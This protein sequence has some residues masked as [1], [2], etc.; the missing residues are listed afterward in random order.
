MKDLPLWTLVVNIDGGPRFNTQAS[1][2]TPKQAVR[3]WLNGDLKYSTG[4]EWQK[5]FSLNSAIETFR[6]TGLQNMH[7]CLVHGNGALIEVTVVRTEKRS[8]PN[9]ALK[10]GRAKKRRAA[11]R[12]S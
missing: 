5:R 3:L 10:S 4:K 12:G 1:A 6:A 11:Q 8:K 7:T 9:R 2:R